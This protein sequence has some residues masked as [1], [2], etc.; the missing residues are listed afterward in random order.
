MI[1]TLQ[2]T[3]TETKDDA[4]DTKDN[5]TDTGTDAENNT[6]YTKGEAKY[7]WGGTYGTNLTHITQRRIQRN[8][9]RYS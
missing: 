8:C 5:T 4:E 9:T 7:T 1:E 3:T 2:W 6:I